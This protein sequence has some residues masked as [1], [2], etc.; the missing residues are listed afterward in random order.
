MNNNL[1]TSKKIFKTNQD[2]VKKW[3]D[4]QGS[5]PFQSNVHPQSCNLA[6]NLGIVWWNCRKL[7]RIRDR[8]YKDGDG[9]ESKSNE[10]AI[11]NKYTYIQTT[12]FIDFEQ[13]TKNKQQKRPESW[14]LLKANIRKSINECI[15]GDTNKTDYLR[16]GNLGNGIGTGSATALD[17]TSVSQRGNTWEQRYLFEAELRKN[18]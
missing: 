4:L 14:V 9:R 16:Q 18:N 7:P 3:S 15:S 12:Q 8:D 6:L 11:T 17:K 5:P 10:I 1:V 2:S 13:P